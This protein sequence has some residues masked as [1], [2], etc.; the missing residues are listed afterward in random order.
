MDH[1]GDEGQLAKF[2]WDI[3]YDPDDLIEYLRSTAE[4]QLAVL[5]EEIEATRAEH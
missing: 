4:P 5:A 1:V 2:A 3:D